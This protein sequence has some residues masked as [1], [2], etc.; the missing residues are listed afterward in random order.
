MTCIERYRGLRGNAGFD[1]TY[2]LSSELSFENNQLHYGLN[3]RNYQT[4]ITLNLSVVLCTRIEYSWLMNIYENGFEGGSKEYETT[5][6]TLSGNKIE[7]DSLNGYFYLIKTKSITRGTMSSINSSVMSSATDIV[8]SGVVFLYELS[9]PFYV[10]IFN[11]ASQQDEWYINLD[12]T[13]R[14]EF[15]F[16]DVTN[17]YIGGY[18]SVEDNIKLTDNFE[19][20]F[21]SIVDPRIS[22]LQ[23]RLFSQYAIEFNRQYTENMY[24]VLSINLNIESSEIYFRIQYTITANTEIRLASETSTKNKIIKIPIGFDPYDIVKNEPK[25]ITSF[26]IKV[27]TGEYLDENG[28]MQYFT[29]NSD[30]CDCWININY[31]GFVSTYCKRNQ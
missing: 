29:F 19:Y 28:E 13:N 20:F 9:T 27:I 22:N 12:N 16:L 1:G 10:I 31:F 8:N 30:I 7:I 18:R 15:Q 21:D 5:K 11:S 17:R 23:Q 2:K 25:P 26:K 4:N 14:C 3:I 6:I 24:A